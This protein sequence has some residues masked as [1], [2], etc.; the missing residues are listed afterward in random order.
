MN[1]TAFCRFATLPTFLGNIDILVG[2]GSDWKRQV[3]CWKHV[4]TAPSRGIAV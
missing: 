3:G 1:K 2:Q 4:K